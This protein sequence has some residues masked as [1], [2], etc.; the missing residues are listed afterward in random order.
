LLL[1]A[2]DVLARLTETDMSYTIVGSFETR[3]QAIGV[4]GLVPEYGIDRGT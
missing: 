3:P 4:K 2:E 1:P